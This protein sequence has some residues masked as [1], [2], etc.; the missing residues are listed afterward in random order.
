MKMVTGTVNTRPGTGH[1]LDRSAQ[2]LDRLSDRCHVRFR[3][4]HLQLVRPD[5]SRQDHG[6]AFET[7]V[8]THSRQVSVPA[9]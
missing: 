5:P 2:R 8:C 9:S 6:N 1:D 4:E 3:T 7:E